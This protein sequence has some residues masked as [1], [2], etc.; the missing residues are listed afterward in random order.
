MIIG[1]II[2]KIIEN[3]F[4]GERN[5]MSKFF[6]ISLFFFVI[7][8]LSPSSHAIDVQE[9]FFQKC[10]S[11]HRPGGEAEGFAPTKY[12]ST[13]WQRFFEREKH[14]RKVDISHLMTDAEVKL[15]MQYLMD[16]AADSDQ[17]EAAG[18]KL[19]K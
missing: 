13:Q 18:L 2:G 6:F 1:K 8:C 17:P 4:Q 15:I 3:N 10:G 11:C 19:M 5:H 14:K 16:H 7:F 12:A 9:L